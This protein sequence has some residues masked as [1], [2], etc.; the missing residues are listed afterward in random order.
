MFT[1]RHVRQVLGSWG[2][3]GTC[4]KELVLVE[5]CECGSYQS[6][7]QWGVCRDGR[8]IGQIGQGFQKGG[9]V[10]RDLEFV[11]CSGGV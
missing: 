4:E 5:G 6:K 7:T 11:I 10:L 9:G 2:I 8:Q 3:W 1:A